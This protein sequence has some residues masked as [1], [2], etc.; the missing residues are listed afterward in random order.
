MD[1]VTYHAMLFLYKT[2]WCPKHNS[3]CCP[4]G[5][6]CF[7]VHRANQLR[8]RPEQ[9]SAAKRWSYDLAATENVNEKRFHPLRYKTTLC[10]IKHCQG[11]P[12][13]WNAHSINEQRWILSTN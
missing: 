6:N 7:D 12:F 1:V 13:C 8:R 4:Y 2:R 9:Q 11:G 5:P 3:H 10:E